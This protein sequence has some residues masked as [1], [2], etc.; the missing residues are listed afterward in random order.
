MAEACLIR[1][2][3]DPRDDIGRKRPEVVELSLEAINGFDDVGHI[4]SHV[5]SMP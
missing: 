3:L 5:P 1:L 4:T 2:L